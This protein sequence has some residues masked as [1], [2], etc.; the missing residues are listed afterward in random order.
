MSGN[1]FPVSMP[2]WGMTMEEGKV[3]DWLISEGEVVSEGDE[4]VEIET[5]KISNVVESQTSGILV[6]QLVAEGSTYKVGSLI[7]VIIEGDV[8]EDEIDN[9][10]R[11]FE[12]EEKIKKESEEATNKTEKI[13]V[14]NLELNFLE[15]LC[16][17]PEEET[18]VFVHGFG[19]DLNSWSY[20]QVE[21]STHFNTI[22]L[23]LPG[24]GGSALEVD[25][26]NVSEL[27][28]ILISLFEKKEINQAHLVGHSLG[29]AI[30]LLMAYTE[31]AIFKTLTLICPVLPG[32]KTNTEFLEG[33]IFADSRKQMRS[34]VSELYANPK[35][36]NRNF[37][38]ETLK[39]RRFDGAKQA[40]SKIKDANFLSS[41]EVS[42]QLPPLEEIKAPIQVI[43]GSEDKIIKFPGDDLVSPNIKIHELNA[44]GHMPQMEEHNQVNKIIEAFIH[45]ARGSI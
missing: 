11:K 36:V 32:C 25:S 41:G 26:G 24:H 44:S 40:L 45:Q 9:F 20:N 43:Q 3:T 39:S 17:K 7:G 22:S 23:D 6:R 21:L 31:P 2:K 8:E 18:I 30:S 4:I 12:T 29:G 15:V 10:I 38:D 16:E 28:E 35:I 37:I 27:S 13:Q 5:D 1:I 14:G 33:F 34:V 19:G 42:F